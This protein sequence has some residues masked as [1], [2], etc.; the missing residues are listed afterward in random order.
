MD[1]DHRV[2]FCRECSRNVYNVSAMTEAEARRVIAER[3]GRVCVRFYQRRDGT[4]L[5]SDCPV[6]RKRTFLAKTAQ[7]AVAVAG[8]AVGLTKLSACGPE[9]EHPELMG[10]AVMGTPVEHDWDAGVEEPAR[11]LMGSV[12]LPPGRPLMGKIAPADKER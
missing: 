5:T 1:G 11:P 10:E 6:G 9:E 8:F 4:V 7:A 3:E 2:R 12:A